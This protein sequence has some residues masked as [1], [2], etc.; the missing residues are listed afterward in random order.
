MKG[1]MTTQTL[2]G[3]S[4][5]GA[6]HWRGD[7]VDGFFGDGAGGA[8]P[9][10]CNEPGYVQVVTG[11]TTS[12]A[13]TAPCNEDLSFRN[14]IVAFEGLVGHEGV[15]SN[16]DM[17]RFADFI[18]QVQLPPNPVAPLDN[19]LTG[20][21]AAGEAVFFSCAAGTAECDHGEILP[22]PFA[23]G[24]VP[25]ATD[26]VEDCDGCH[27]L[28][29]LNGFFGTA[30]EQTFENEPQNFKVAH[31]RNLYQ[32]VGM[33][34]SSG[35]TTFLGDQVRGTGFLHDGS[36][37]TVFSF[38]TLGTAFPGLLPGEPEDLEQH[39]LAFPTDLAPI[40]GQQVTLA[41]VPDADTDARI[42]LLIAQAGAPF[43]SA[44]LGGAV[45]E[46][47]LVV[48]GVLNGETRGWVYDTGLTL[49]QSD[50]AAETHT[51]GDLRT[52]A[53]TAGQELTYTCVPPGSG[54]RVGIDRDEDGEL[55]GDERDAGTDP[56]NAGS[57]VGACTDGIDNDGDGD[58]DGAD[59][60][61]TGGGTPDIENPACDD[62]FDNDADG[63]FD[64]AGDPACQTAASDNER[65]QCQDGFNNDNQLGTDF[66]GGVSVLG[67]GN[68]DPN[69]PDPQC[70]QAWTA[71]EATTSGSPS[72][73]LGAELVVVMPI[74]GMLYRR[75]RRPA[76]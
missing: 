38:L 67:A 26:T 59:A 73:G 4:T 74:L 16:A 20:D 15:I 5:H 22:P 13:T 3:M 36:I 42:V 44:V 29:P 28:D 60:G 37:D 39:A 17:Q 41:G 61:C 49:F 21:A 9:D 32:K 6:L 62:G 56:A 1:P 72:C 46:C 64:L 58:T 2:R 19:V 34:G 48:K 8:G 30:G 11:D 10:P 33:F 24:V 57:I 52:N 51:D 50:R 54:V 63:L 14:F 69:G 55:D 23:S 18:L 40:V 31:M 66:D 27:N 25:G 45:T 35:D 75:R 47:D 12:V 43:D 70:V 68:G 65:S 76:A 71:K 53:L 7:R